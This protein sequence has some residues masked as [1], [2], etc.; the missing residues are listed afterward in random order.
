MKTQDP[1]F[2]TFHNDKYPKEME[3][4]GPAKS[5]TGRSIGQDFSRKDDDACTMDNIY[6]IQHTH[7][8]DLRQ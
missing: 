3:I 7:K 5:L 4:L 2:C 8:K 6:Q 1:F